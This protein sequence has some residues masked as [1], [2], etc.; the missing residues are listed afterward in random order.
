ME[1][2]GAES[3]ECTEYRDKDRAPAGLPHELDGFGGVVA[4]AALP[5]FNDTDSVQQTGYSQVIVRIVSM[6]VEHDT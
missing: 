2:S 3:T 1:I 6:A 4:D 5:D